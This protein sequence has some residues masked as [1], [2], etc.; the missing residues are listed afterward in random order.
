MVLSRSLLI[1]VALPGAMGFVAPSMP[2]SSGRSAA[3]ALR[4]GS[5]SVKVSPMSAHW[6][7][8]TGE[9]N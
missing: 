1:A 5:T 2:L 7:E 4:S 9:G 6:S 3:P 8:G